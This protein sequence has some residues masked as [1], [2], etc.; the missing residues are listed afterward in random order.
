MLSKLARAVA[1]RAA[2]TA[3]FT[4]LAGSARLPPSRGILSSRPPATSGSSSYRTKFLLL[5]PLTA[6]L[7]YSKLAKEE[8]VA[9]AEE[10]RDFEVK[11]AARLMDGDMME[12]KVGPEDG[13]KILVAKIK[14]QYYAAGNFCTHFGAPLGNSLLIDDK[15]ICPWHFAAFSVK[16]GNVEQSPAL[17]GL[18]TYPTYVDASGNLHVKLPA[19]LPTSDGVTSLGKRDPNNKETYVIVGGGPAGL[20][21]AE[22]LR[23]CGFT[24]RIQVISNENFLPYDRTIL[25]KWVTGAE[26]PALQ[27]RSA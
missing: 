9:M 3:A 6:A 11:E 10:L 18:P 2:L 17:S 16:D 27:L 8:K 20:S 23:R 24:G 19:K 22:T 12:V 1:P 21:A 5:A 25:S 14:G 13:D 26:V 15:V 4:R 7:A